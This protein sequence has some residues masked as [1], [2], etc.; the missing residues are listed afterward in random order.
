M[1]DYWENDLLDRKQD[2]AFLYDF[3][4]GEIDKRAAQGKTSSYVLNV[5][6]EWGGGKTFFLEGLARDMETKGHVVVR[7]NAWRDDHA[8]DPYI[9]IMASIDKALSPLI[10]KPGQLKTAWTKTKRSGG[11]IAIKIG[12]ALTKSLIKKTTGVVVDEITEIVSGGDTL[13]DAVTEAG[14]ITL[15]QIEKLFDSSL[16]TMINAFQATDA[17][18]TDFRSKLEVTIE[19]ITPGH[20]KPIF[21]LIDE[22]DR[23][24][25]SFAVQLL[26][27]VKHLFDVN[28]VVFVF[29]TNAQQLQY[30]IAGAYG[31]GFDGLRY[32][33]RFF[34]RTYVFA[35]PSLE[36][37][38]ET[39]CKDLPRGKIRAPEGKLEEAVLTGCIA[40][41]FDIR[42]IIQ[43]MDIISST[44]S[45]WPHKIPTDI[46]ILLP[47]VIHFHLTGKPTWPATSEIP[48]IEY[49]QMIRSVKNTTRGTIDR[50][51]KMINIYRHARGLMGS[52]DAMMNDRESKRGDVNRDYASDIF[53]PE[54][55]GLQIHDRTK[56]SIQ[57]DLL[58]L[59]AQAGRFLGE[60]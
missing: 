29:A 24:R 38:V 59:V 19:A 44:L 57:K 10:K 35:E 4:M 33:K 13:P 2:A 54:W 46:T 31:P 41:G 7:V 36:R 5:D 51:F 11:A 9:A 45:A 49:W 37:L 16:E 15:A 48:S 18:M 42:S 8:Q 25:P 34:D 47:L 50:S 53:L 1:T 40:F 32:L 21:I 60:K 26:E 30:S 43:V 6:A 52:I 22:L 23:C 27:R 55:N 58:S 14:D 3:L 20:P 56:P 39:L 17:A 12:G 28:G